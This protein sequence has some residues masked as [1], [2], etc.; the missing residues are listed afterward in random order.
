MIPQDANLLSEFQTSFTVS[1]SKPELKKKRRAP[2]SV[3]LSDEQ[4]KQ[5]RQDALGMSL[6][7]YALSRLF[8]EEKPKRKH[9]KPTKR[10]KA[11]AKALRRLGGCGINAFLLSQILAVEEGRL[12]LSKEEERELRKAYAE[13][14]AVRRDLVA[15]VGL[16]AET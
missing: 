15:A 6:N 5:L 3:R 4:W 8:G 16:G 1:A 11:I 2:L 10:D 14:D 12:L 7:A 13:F 9:R